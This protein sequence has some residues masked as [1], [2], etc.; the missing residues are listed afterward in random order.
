MRAVSDRPLPRAER[1]R[2]TEE[3]ILGAARALFAEV[4]FE[5]ATIRAVAAAAGVD[6]ALVMQYFGSKRELFARAAQVAPEPGAGL[7]PDELVRQLLRTLNLKMG[8]LPQGSLAMMRSML[9]HPEAADSARAALRDQIDRLAAAVQGEDA[10]LRA[11]LMTAVVL[12][13]TVGH[14]L[15]ELPELREAP[16]ERIAGL[17]GPALR[18][19]AGRPAGG[20]ADDA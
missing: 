3:R 1:R 9:T 2:R 11:A 14:H 7:G 19:L 6:P 18:V 13:A 20:P 8:E 12:G 10:R 4:G 15:L 5:R 16:P 17:L